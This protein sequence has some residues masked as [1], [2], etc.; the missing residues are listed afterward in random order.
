MNVFNYEILISGILITRF[1]TS[2][3]FIPILAVHRNFGRKIHLL[4]I[5]VE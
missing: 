4:A 5:N 2:I 1:D 3:L